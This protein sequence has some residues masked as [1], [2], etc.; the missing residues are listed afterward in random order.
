M[1]TNCALCG[2]ARESSAKQ[3][4]GREYDVC[5]VCW[6]ELDRKLEGKGRETKRRTAV[7]IPTPERPK[8][9]PETPRPN[10]PPKI[11][12]YS[13]FAAEARKEEFYS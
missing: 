3:I 4:E 10:E 1:N 9:Q 13:S 12:F 11:W 6:A 2:E 5:A 7:L 8:E